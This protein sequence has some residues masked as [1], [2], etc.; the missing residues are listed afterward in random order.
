MCLKCILYL[1]KIIFFLSVSAMEQNKGT[2]RDFT[3]SDPLVLLWLYKL[4][5]T[6]T[7]SSMASVWVKISDKGSQC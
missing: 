6:G 3:I 7:L 1:Y 2:G 4:L 5:I